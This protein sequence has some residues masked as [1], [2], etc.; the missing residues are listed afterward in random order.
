MFMRLHIPV[1]VATFI[2]LP[3]AQSETHWPSFRGPAAAGVVAGANGP[4]SWDGATESNVAW[5]TAIPG[6][7]HSCPAIWGDQ[8][9]ITTAVADGGDDDPLKIGLYGDIAPVQDDRTYRFELYCLDKKT[10]RVQWKHTAHEGVPAIK[11]HSK[12]SH[13]NSTP[14]TNGQFVVAFF[15]S[16]GLYCYDMSGKLVWKRSFG[17]LDSGF[18][19]VPPAQ[20]GFGS[21][22]II[23]EDRVIVQCDVQKGSFLA[24]LKLSDGTDVWRTARSDVPTW[25]TPTVH[26]ES[27]QVLVNGYR[28]LGGY[29]LKTGEVRWKIEGAGDIPVPTPIIGHGCVFMTSAHGSAAP[30]YA[31]RL[32]AKGTIN[33]DVAD[34]NMLW[35]VKRNGAY[36]QTPIILG[37]HLYN[38]R[39]NGVLTCYDA[40]S[41]DVNYRTRLGDG[42]TGFTASGV[43]CGDKLY[44]TSEEGTTYVV[45]RGLTF[46][47]IATNALGETCMATPAIS[48]ERLFFRARRHVFAIGKTPVKSNSDVPAGGLN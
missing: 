26:A 28:H 47:L 37:D 12:S 44:Y 34:P 13:A 8:L 3:A 48:S 41:G 11:R 22:P 38:C 39:D 2:P 27:S 7:G 4:V 45:Q 29:D 43:A 35:S 33:K 15:G 17:T 24:A 14:A 40:R 31:V 19:M 30:I 20:W 1:L 5:K 18:Y 25:S 21:S 6:L 23:H 32:G 42:M 16:E 46:K 36:M 10:G 9:F